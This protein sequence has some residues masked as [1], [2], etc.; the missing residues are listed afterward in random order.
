MIEFPKKKYDIIYADPAWHYEGAQS[1]GN[2]YCAKGVTW[3][4]TGAFMHYATMPTDEITALPVQ[5]IAKD[6][7]LLFM[8]AVSPLFPDAMRVIEA[9]G[10]EYKT[11][12][13]VWHKVNM[14]VGYYT[15]P[16]C[17]MCLVAKRGAIPQPRG[18]RNVRQFLCEYRQ[19]HSKKPDEIRRRI[20][21]MFPSQRKIELFA[22]SK[23]NGWDAWGN[24]VIP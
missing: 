6:N 18:A 22:R 15:L 16:E 13:F 4:K 17:E 10:F 14:N 9:W 19:R 5:S 3:G 21:A 1:H 7:C 24:E 2:K 8:W 11:I 20:E 23:H 12:A